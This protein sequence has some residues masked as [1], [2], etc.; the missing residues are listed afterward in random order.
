MGAATRAVERL[1]GALSAVEA[2]DGASALEMGDTRA[3]FK[4]AVDPFLDKIG[5]WRG[6]WRLFAPEPRKS[7]VTVSARFIGYGVSL[8]WTS[9]KLERTRRV[10]KVLYRP[11]HEV[12]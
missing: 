1:E 6:D 7:N 4:S 8:E 9:P 3:R 5:L 12:L 11:P 10:G 2:P